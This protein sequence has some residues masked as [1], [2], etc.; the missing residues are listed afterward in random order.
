MSEQKN[1]S[2]AYIGKKEVK[3]DTVNGTGTVWFGHGD[4]QLYPAHL[5]ARLLA[6][7]AVWMLGSQ[8]AAGGDEDALKGDAPD[9]D[10]TSDEFG[11]N[12]KALLEGAGAP[13]I[14]KETDED[15]IADRAALEARQGMA[16]ATK[17]PLP[18]GEPSKQPEATEGEE[19]EGYDLLQ[20][21]RD[22]PRDG[23]H[24]SKTGNPFVAKVR[25]L[26]NDPELTTEEVKAAWDKVKT[27][28]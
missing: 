10:D 27:E 6:H 9:P 8:F 26:A 12:E 22:M 5:A 24:V 23:I 7:K 20:V 25:E 16:E 28:G 15:E 4:L 13:G 19:A 21:L 2:I 18:A 3:R 11:L 17:P 1:V 14:Q